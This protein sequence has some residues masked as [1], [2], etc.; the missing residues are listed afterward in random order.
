MW[1]NHPFSER[2]KTAKSCGGGGWRQEG[3][4]EQSLKKVNM[5]YRGFFIKN[6]GLGTLSQLCYDKL[7]SKK[8]TLNA[9]K[10]IEF[11]AFVAVLIL[12]IQIVLLTL[13]NLNKPY[14]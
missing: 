13:Q 8:K 5:Q 14:Y 6:E 11:K 10:V 3:R 7:F 2:N 9:Y 12:F 4:G 1:C